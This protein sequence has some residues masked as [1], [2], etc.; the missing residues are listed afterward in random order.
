MPGMPYDAD[1]DLRLIFPMPRWEDYLALAFDEIRQYGA[2][3]CRSCG[4]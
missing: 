4:A 1:G 2:D 3:W